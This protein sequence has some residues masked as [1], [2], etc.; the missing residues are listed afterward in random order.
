[1]NRYGRGILTLG[2][3]AGNKMMLEIEWW[4]EGKLTNRPAINARRGARYLE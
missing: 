2:G 4:D 3:I 1:M